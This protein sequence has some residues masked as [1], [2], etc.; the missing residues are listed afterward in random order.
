MCDACKNLSKVWDESQR[1]M[2]TRFNNKRTGMPT[3]ILVQDSDKGA[4]GVT[5][6]VRFCPWC[7]S[8]LTGED[9]E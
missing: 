9:A 8:R 5:V 3:F 4:Q 7:G 1:L 2:V 6:E